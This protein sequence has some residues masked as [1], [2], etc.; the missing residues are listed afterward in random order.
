MGVDQL[1]ASSTVNP[2]RVSEI[3]LNNATIKIS[4]GTDNFTDGDIVIVGNWDGVEVAAVV[5]NASDGTGMVSVDTTVSGDL[6]GL[7]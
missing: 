6:G 1:S 7:L 5:G 4:D 3:P 2:E